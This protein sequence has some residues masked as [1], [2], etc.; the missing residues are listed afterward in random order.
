MLI[1]TDLRSELNKVTIPTIIFH[2]VKIKYA[3][4][5]WQSMQKGIKNSTIVRF[6]NSDHG[7]FLEER[8]KFNSELTK[9]IK[10]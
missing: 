7:L 10:L 1:D 9:F 3:T 4:L 5:R 8:E 6:E 2:G